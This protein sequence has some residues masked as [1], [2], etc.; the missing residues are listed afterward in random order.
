MRSIATAALVVVLAHLSGCCCL[1]I[2][3]VSSPT[4]PREFEAPRVVAEIEPTLA[5]EAEPTLP[6]R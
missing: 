6:S 2:P 3:F 1:P 5:V 4:G